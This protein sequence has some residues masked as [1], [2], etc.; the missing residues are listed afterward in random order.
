MNLLEIRGEIGV[1]KTAINRAKRVVREEIRIR[2]VGV[3]KLI[4]PRE[5]IGVAS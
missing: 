3:G 2:K 5:Q 4:L 1:G